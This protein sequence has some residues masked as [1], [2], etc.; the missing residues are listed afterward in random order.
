MA[1]LV[2]EGFRNSYRS[3]QGAWPSIQQ[4]TTL[5]IIHRLLLGSRV[6]AFVGRLLS[7]QRLHHGLL[8]TE[9]AGSAVDGAP[10]SVLALDWDRWGRLDHSGKCSSRSS[11]SKSRLPHD[12]IPLSLDIAIS[13]PGSGASL[14]GRVAPA[15]IKKSAARRA[16]EAPVVG[17]CSRSYLRDSATKSAKASRSPGMSRTRHWI[18]RN[19]HAENGAPRSQTARLAV[20]RFQE[21]VDSIVVTPVRA[22]IDPPD[23]CLGRPPDAD[24][25]TCVVHK[26]PLCQ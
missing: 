8:R 15:A 13:P 23:S 6:H 24:R 19:A 14:G 11:R 4:P 20:R 18:T 25:P 12:T 16:R 3:S 26:A 1:M 10:S 7:Y 9:A 22:S 17:P 21:S 5:D 2:H